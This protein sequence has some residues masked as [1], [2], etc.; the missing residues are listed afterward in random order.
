MSSNTTIALKSILIS[1]FA[2]FNAQFL[3]AETLIILLRPV[4]E[5]DHQDVLLSDVALISL[6]GKNAVPAAIEQA[7]LAVIPTEEGL[8]LIDK[9]VINVRL[10]LLGL[11]TDDYQLLGPDQI[12]VSRRKSGPISPR[13]PRFK[14]IATTSSVSAESTGLQ[15]APLSDL[16]VEQTIQSSLS[17][18]FG[19]PTEDVRA[20]LL[21]PFMDDRLQKLE[22]GNAVSTRSQ[23]IAH[24]E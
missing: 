5:V 19:L 13:D 9:S 20:Q 16:L 17:H 6:S 2:I 7:D 14:L 23:I 11:K 3:M 8:A 1:T 12:F 18:Q 4:A 24:N 21:R 22:D 10:R 15:T